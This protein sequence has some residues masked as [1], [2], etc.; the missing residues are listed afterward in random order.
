[1][2]NIL[3][4]QARTIKRGIKRTTLSEHVHIGSVSLT[5]IL[6][7]FTAVIS[8]VYLMAV[9]RSSTQGYVFKELQKERSDLIK[10]G[11]KWDMEIARVRSLPNIT[12][13]PLVS[14]MRTSK[15][16]P[17]FIRE[18]SAFAKTDK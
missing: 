15:D 14:D 16:M 18:N 11:E 10:E 7:I 3:V 1:M 5:L 2:A 13:H 8:T 17:L 4:T 12:N 9:N 6:I